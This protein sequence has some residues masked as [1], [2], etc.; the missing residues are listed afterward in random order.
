MKRLILTLLLASR[1]V[2]AADFT[3]DFDRKDALFDAVHIR[4]PTE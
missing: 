3:D 2:H 4:T 1:Q